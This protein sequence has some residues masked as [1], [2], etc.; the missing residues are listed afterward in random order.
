MYLVEKN[1]SVTALGPLYLS[2]MQI[3][4]EEFQVLNESGVE[5]R[6]F[7][8]MRDESKV[9]KFPITSV[10]KGHRTSLSVDGQNILSCVEFRPRSED[11]DLIFGCVTEYGLLYLFLA[12]GD[13]SPYP[14]N[15]HFLC[16]FKKRISSW[17]SIQQKHLSYALSLNDLTCLV[18]RNAIVSIPEQASVLIEDIIDSNEN[19]SSV[20][21]LESFTSIFKISRKDALLGIDLSSEKFLITSPGDVYSIPSGNLKSNSSVEVSTSAVS[22]HREIPEYPKLPFFKS[23]LVSS[24]S[25]L[26][27]IDSEPLE[28]FLVRSKSKLS[29]CFFQ[30]S[31]QAQEQVLE[32]CVGLFS[33]AEVLLAEEGKL[34]SVQQQS[35]SI[36]KNIQKRVKL[37]KKLRH[38]SWKDVCLLINFD[39]SSLSR[40]NSLVETLSRDLKSI[41]SSRS[42]V[43]IESIAAP[44]TR[45]RAIS[46]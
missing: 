1:G 2:G 38:L 18:F 21:L 28:S 39:A 20:L 29:P 43:P 15:L 42:P 25:E 8:S 41:E 3:S 32:N 44:E 30:L 35:L 24:L 37:S 40:F 9:V 13:F 33:T 19:D 14:R 36:Q 34:D 22:N 10:W 46:M 26:A 45:K 5:S 27:T 23:D 12:S 16:C 11:D 4:D 7:S 17:E 6:H 31:F